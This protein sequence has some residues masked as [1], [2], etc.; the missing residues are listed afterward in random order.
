MYCTFELSILFVMS[1]NLGKFNK[2]SCLVTC[3]RLGP[4]ARQTPEGLRKES[5]GRQGWLD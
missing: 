5:P 3:N 1:F 4:N 2:L